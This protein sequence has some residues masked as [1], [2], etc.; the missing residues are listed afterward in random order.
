MKNEIKMAFF[1]WIAPIIGLNAEIEEIREGIFASTFGLNVQPM[2]DGNGDALSCEFEQDRSEPCSL[3]E[4]SQEAT[5]CGMTIDEASAKR[6]VYKEI[7][8]FYDPDMPDPLLFD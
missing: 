3:A 5:K 2:S 1:G 7:T 8:V 4:F 6:W